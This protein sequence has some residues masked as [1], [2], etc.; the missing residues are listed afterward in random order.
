LPSFDH[1]ERS[2]NIQDLSQKVFDLIIVGGGI[3]GAGAARDAASRGLSVAL[4]E[5]NDFSSGTS[6]KSSK[7]IHGGI[8]YLENFEFKLV[9]EA[10]AERA[11]LFKMAPHLSD[12]LR[13]VIPIFK[14]SRVGM[15]KM[16]L[17]ML[18]YDLLAMFKSPKMHEK[19]S[20]SQTLERASGLLSQG[21]LGAYEYSDGYMDDDRLVFESLRSAARWGA[22]SANYCKVTSLNVEANHVQSL[23]VQDTL[24]GQTFTLKGKQFVGALGPWTDFFG[25][26][27]FNQWKKRMRPTKGIHLTFAKNRIPLEKAV[28]M[29]VEKRILFVIPRDEYVLVG[30]TDTDF[31]EDPGNVD[32]NEDDV[33]YVLKALQNYF[34][35]LSLTKKDIIASYAGVRPLVADGS[36]SEGKT[37]R[38]HQI[39]S[40]G[41]NWTQ[42]AGGKYTTYRKMA[43]ELID[44][45][46]K[47]FSTDEKK[48]FVKSQTKLPLN[49]EATVKNIDE[50]LSQSKNKADELGVPE[51]YFE[52]LVK[53]HGSSGVELARIWQELD[54]PNSE[55]PDDEA[56]YWMLE[57]HHAIN[58]TM[59][60]SLEDFYFRRTSLFLSKKDHGVSFLPSVGKIFTKK[61]GW[62]EDQLAKQKQKL[63]GKI[64]QE[65]KWKQ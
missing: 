53:R 63:I 10:L 27:F 46:L 41:N 56:R 49:P 13:F 16:G 33:S 62:T 7:L 14:G 55:S 31:T 35:R 8:R 48:S 64:D 44:E 25:D 12:P 18:L 51:S 22:V 20:P 54:V 3:N 39:F 32:V 60:L 50:L 4:V 30:T 58:T 1:V 11:R 19:L 5:A 59:C 23:K 43:E 52:K 29:A 15:F 40:W 34:P 57:A 28:V 45:V 17:G 2:K 38:E 21:L 9:F 24:S 65:L 42:I 37:S 36:S 61:F 47:K 26:R 6:S